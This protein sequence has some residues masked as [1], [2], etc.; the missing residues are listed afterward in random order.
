MSLLR[1]KCIK[2]YP[3]GPDYGMHAVQYNEGYNHFYCEEDK[4]DGKENCDVE[5]PLDFP[6]NWELLDE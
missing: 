6:D 5:N 4:L 2:T 3:N 1:F